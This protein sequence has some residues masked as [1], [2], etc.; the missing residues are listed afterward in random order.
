MAVKEAQNDGVVI[1][2]G[3]DIEKEARAAEQEALMVLT[4]AKAVIVSNDEQ[5][6]DADRNFGAIKQKMK[7]VEAQR[8]A[9]TGPINTSLKL[10]NAAFKRP[11]ETL[12]AALAYYEKPMKEYQLELHKKR[13]AAEEAAAKERQRLDEEANATAQA[14][15]EKAQQAQREADEAAQKAAAAAAATTANPLE[16]LLLKEEADE[17]QAAADAQFQTS[18]QAYRDTRLVNVAE[19]YVPKLTGGGSRVNKRWKYRIVDAALVPKKYWMIDEALIAQDVREQK[20]SFSAPG[21]AIFEDLSIG[22]R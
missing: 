5:Y 13:R 19:E 11:M 22:G 16:T 17:K 12:E 21:I 18:Q 9:I 3:I 6:L 8:V 2:P 7:E 4:T 14:E 1:A 10:I 20:E 15:R